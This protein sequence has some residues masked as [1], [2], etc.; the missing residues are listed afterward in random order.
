MEAL[1]SSE[2]LESTCKSARRY[3]PEDQ[4]GLL[5]RLEN[6]KPHIIISYTYFYNLFAVCEASTYYMLH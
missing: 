1:C 5:H 6:H 3:N 4:H 2:T